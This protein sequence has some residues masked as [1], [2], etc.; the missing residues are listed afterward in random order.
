MAIL[1]SNVDCFGA[2]RCND[3]TSFRTHSNMMQHIADKQFICIWLSDTFYIVFCGSVLTSLDVA[4]NSQLLLTL[5]ANLV[6][7]P[8]FFGDNEMSNN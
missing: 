7:I 4:T 2:V 3:T 8:F 1:D 6:W 5:Q